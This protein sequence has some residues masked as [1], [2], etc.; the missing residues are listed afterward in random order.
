MI[1][2]WPFFQ[3]RNSVLITRAL[4]AERFTAEKYSVLARLSRM[5]SPWSARASL[6]HS[7]MRVP[8]KA[9]RSLPRA[10]ASLVPI[11]RR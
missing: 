4:S 7:L 2:Y 1:L 3:S 9:Y 11:S 8:Q 5:S 10:L 6:S